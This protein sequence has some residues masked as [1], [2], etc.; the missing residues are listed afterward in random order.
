MNRSVKLYNLAPSPH[1][2]K[3]RLA[4]AFK[5]IPYERI[6]VEPENRQALIAISGQ[7]LSPVLLHGDAVVYDSYAILRYLDANWPSSPRLFSADRD[8]MKRIEEWELFARTEAAPPVGMIFRDLRAP[9][10]DPDRLKKANEL[11]NRAASRLEE[12]LAKTSHLMGDA[13]NAADFTLAPMVYYGAVPEGADKGNPVAAH[14]RRHL[15][16]EGAP[17]TRDWISRV[18]AWEGR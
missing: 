6:P 18:M 16:I 15:K 2:I 11:I 5:K 7:P 1:N 17:K 9:A 4:L 14:F 8:T 10:P 13:P 3:V 12:A